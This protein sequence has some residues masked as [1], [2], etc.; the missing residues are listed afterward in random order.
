MSRTKSAKK[1]LRNAQ[2]KQKHNSQIKQRVKKL[3]K[4]ARKG[5]HKEIKTIFSILDKIASRKII[6][7]NKAA[8]LKSRLS[9]FVKQ[10]PKQQTKSKS[11]KK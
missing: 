2:R 1:S 8:R 4:G 7:K 9:R 10:A 11:L 3:I 5:K 6:H